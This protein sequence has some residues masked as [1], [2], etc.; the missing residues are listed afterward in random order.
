[1]PLAHWQN[2]L[3]LHDHLNVCSRWLDK[4]QQPF[5]IKKKK[6]E[7]ET[8]EID[9][10]RNVCQHTIFHKYKPTNNI[11]STRNLK[12]FPQGQK[13]NSRQIHEHDAGKSGQTN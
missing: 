5:F 4:T 2:K 12:V 8:D 6:K 11:I 7:K 3:K 13:V 1:M 10:R 9:Y